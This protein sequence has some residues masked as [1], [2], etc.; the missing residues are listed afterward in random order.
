MENN[1][2]YEFPCDQGTKKEK[3]LKNEKKGQTIL[4]LFFSKI[5][6]L[7]NLHK[8]PSYRFRLGWRDNWDS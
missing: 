6:L 8:R 3:R 2:K 1:F 4:V 5:I 7:T